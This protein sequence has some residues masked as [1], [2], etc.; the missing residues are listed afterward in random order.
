MC[1]EHTPRA[2]DGGEK[3]VSREFAGLG[4]EGR[5]AAV[6]HCAEHDHAV[7]GGLMNVIVAGGVVTVVGILV[8]FV[9]VIAGL[10][11]LLA[12]L[13]VGVAAYL[14]HQR[15]KAA[16]LAVRPPLPVLPSLDSVNVLETLRG[17][18]RLGEDG[19][20]VSTPQPT[21]GTL[22][23]V[24]TLAR[25]DRERLS[26]YRARFGLGQDDPVE[27]SAGFA[28]LK[29]E[30]GLT[31]RPEPAQQNSLLISDTGIAFPGQVSGHPLFSAEH[32]RPAGQWAVH[33]PYGLPQA[34]T[35]RSI[36]IWIVPS[37]VPASD[38]RTLQ[39]DL[40]WGPLREERPGEARKQLTFLRFE[41]IKLIVPKTWGN[42]ESASPVNAYISNPESQSVRTIEWRPLSPTGPE[43]TG[44]QTLTIRFEKQISQADMLIGSLRA[45]FKGTLS[46]VTDIR[47]YRPTGGGWLQAPKAT[48]TM[49]AEV[50]F[51]L[52][53]NSVR[54]Q[55]VRVVPD[56]L[57]DV[58]RPDVDEFTGVIPDYRT[59]IELTDELSDSGY[60]VK[61]VIENP[62]RGGGR[63]NLV[64]RYWDIAGR[65]YDG[66]F[67]I[68]FHLTLTGEEEYLGSIQA[69][70]GSTA[71]RLSVHGSYV[72]QNME[73]QVVSEWDALH[74]LVATRL[75]S[76]EM[77]SA[78]RE[79]DTRSPGTHLPPAYGY[80]AHVPPAQEWDQSPPVAR[81]WAQSPPPPPSAQEWDQSP[82]VAR[83]WAQSP[84]PPPSAQEWD[85]SPPVAREWAQSPLP[86]PSPSPPAAGP[87]PGPAAGPGESRMATLRRRLEAA[88]DA[89]VEGRISEETYRRIE[90]NIRAELARMSAQNDD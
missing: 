85:Q 27:F 13:G 76:R 61:Q 24:M 43:K 19:T 15:R 55:A 46:G 45:A 47:M 30:A 70:A 69:N 52:S 8:M 78:A 28:V 59:V 14:A 75:K 22:D 68:D 2:V 21:E 39:V 4:L 54:Y 1:Q 36:P 81:E 71:A 33:L 63:A 58:G 31:F 86:P 57:K 20:Y 9:N 35:P 74:D 18:V 10:V 29:G 44:S 12:G 77:F 17:Q 51:Q 60:Y 80:G 50:D 56:G 48:V 82:P 62:P 88:T 25:P 89:L 34:R 64:N 7:K 73:N 16:A 72:N 53:L 32:G 3:P 5:Q 37:L 90:G 23:V 65:R 67:P 83:E 49:E 26:S 66:V 38:K 79:A 84:P 40:H 41:L 6:Y 87:G 42:V 11:L